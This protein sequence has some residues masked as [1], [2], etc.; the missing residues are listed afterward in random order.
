[1]AQVAP[2][3]RPAWL[4]EK[5]LKNLLGF[6]RTVP[7]FA[8]EWPEWDEDSRLDFI[9]E[10]PIERETL[11]R[12]VDAAAAGLLNEHQRCK[13]LELS[14]LIETHRNTVEQMLGEPI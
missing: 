7:E 3:H 13:W 5:D 4:I 9:H 1:M 6:W 2:E 11:Q 14:R 10:W 8:A 12:V